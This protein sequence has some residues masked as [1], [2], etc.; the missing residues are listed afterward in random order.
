MIHLVKEIG[1]EK[2]K[3]LEE[4]HLKEMDELEKIKQESL[5]EEILKE[6]QEKLKQK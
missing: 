5:Y 6:E 3:K 1:N 2:K 4:E